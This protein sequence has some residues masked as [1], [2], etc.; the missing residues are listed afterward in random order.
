MSQFA[1]PGMPP[2]GMP[3]AMAAMAGMGVHFEFYERLLRI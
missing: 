2:M 1:L 3:G